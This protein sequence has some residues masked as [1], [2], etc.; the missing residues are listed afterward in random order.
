M[1]KGAFSRLV[2]IIFAKLT[3][4][5]LKSMTVS[6]PFALR[7]MISTIDIIGIHL[8]PLI[9]VLYGPAILA[10]CSVTLHGSSGSVFV[11][12]YKACWNGG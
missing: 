6:G 12:V 5:I 9:V 4:H 10:I 2:L 8:D 1:F 7:N 11:I 3:H